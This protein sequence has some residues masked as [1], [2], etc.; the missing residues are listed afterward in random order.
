M[1]VRFSAGTIPRPRTS[2]SIEFKCRHNVVR[3]FLLGT[4]QKCFFYEISPMFL[5]RFQRAINAV[6]RFTVNFKNIF[7][8]NRG[9]DGSAGLT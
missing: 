1:A 9:Y 7:V 3:G 4:V 5:R 2:G 6:Y 8:I